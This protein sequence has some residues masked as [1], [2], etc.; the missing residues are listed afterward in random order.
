[1]PKFMPKSTHLFCSD[2]VQERPANK[3]RTETARG[4][5]DTTVN[6]DLHDGVG[7][8]EAE[9]EVLNNKIDDPF[10]QEIMDSIN[11]MDFS[12]HPYAET[13]RQ[14]ME[15]SYVFYGKEGLRVQLNYIIAN[16]PEDSDEVKEIERCIKKLSG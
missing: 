1:M 13:Y 14:A 9:H 16:L 2:D 11:E 7:V 6:T 5:V 3:Y 15:E 4:T 10:A 12:K 8:I